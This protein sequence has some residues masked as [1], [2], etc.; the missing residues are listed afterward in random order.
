MRL[1]T[2]PQPGE[3]FAGEE[4]AFLHTKQGMDIEL[5]ATDKRAKILP[6]KVG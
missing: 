4:I 2:P 3:A 1:I 5:I 6:Q